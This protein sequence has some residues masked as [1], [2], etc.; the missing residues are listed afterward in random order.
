VEEV[1]LQGV[2]AW[3]VATLLEAVVNAVNKDYK[4]A[5]ESGIEA[6]Q[7]RWDHLVIRCIG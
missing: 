2:D 3:F 7:A 4:H 5:F 1:A 6:I